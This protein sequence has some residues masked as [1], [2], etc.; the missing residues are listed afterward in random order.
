MGNMDKKIVVLFHKNCSSGDGFGA[1]WAAWKKFGKKVVALDHHVSLERATK[2]AHE[3]RYALNKSGATLAW[4]YFFPNKKIPI[5]L[6]YLE[7]GDIW[8]NK[9][10]RVREFFAIL[11]TYERDFKTWDRL[12]KEFELP[13]V[14]KE[15]LDRGAAVLSYQ[16]RLIEKAIEDAYE[17]RFRGFTIFASNSS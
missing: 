6:Q 16:K 1:A 11:H 10:P 13:K 4:Q 3:N 17:V 7:D 12:V 14:R 15:H 9:M 2:M 8:R 5:L